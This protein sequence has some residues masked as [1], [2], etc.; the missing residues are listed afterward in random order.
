MGELRRIGMLHVLSTAKAKNDARPKSEKEIVSLRLLKVTDAGLEQVA[1]MTSLLHLDLTG[2][3]VTDKGLRHLT[4]LKL[5]SLN[6]AKTNITKVGLKEL[7][8]LK[9]LVRLSLPFN[10]VPR[11]SEEGAF[12]KA[13]PQ[14]VVRRGY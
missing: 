4:G 10:A 5:Q 14:C 13:M 3:K 12:R 1:D 7:V 6:L 9:S 2:A 11:T 8:G